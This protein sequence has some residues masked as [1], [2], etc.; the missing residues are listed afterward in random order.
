MQR[1]G[2]S[3]CKF[4]RGSRNTVGVQ[5]LIYCNLYTNIQIR[6]C[7]NL[8]GINKFVILE[9]FIRVLTYS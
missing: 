1:G 4:G 2:E 7:T 8:T 6:V 3:F 5:Y 9:V